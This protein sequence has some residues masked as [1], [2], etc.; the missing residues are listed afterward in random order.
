M[1]ITCPEPL[2]MKLQLVIIYDYDSNNL[3]TQ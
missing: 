1:K 3:I 2:D